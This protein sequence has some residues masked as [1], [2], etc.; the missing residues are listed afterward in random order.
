MLEKVFMSPKLTWEVWDSN[1]Q[2][3]KNIFQVKKRDFQ[4]HFSYRGLEGARILTACR[5]SLDHVL[6]AKKDILFP[7]VP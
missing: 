6:L 1:P 5:G 3:K 7:T 4:C 2:P